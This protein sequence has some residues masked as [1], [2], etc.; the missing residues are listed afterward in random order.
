MGLY[1]ERLMGLVRDKA[2]GSVF[3][4]L[5]MVSV[6]GVIVGYSRYPCLPSNYKSKVNIFCILVYFT[7]PLFIGLRLQDANKCIT[8]SAFFLGI[9][10]I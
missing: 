10:S 9:L 6:N 4:S 3:L 2:A 1:L 8:A 5:P 7:K